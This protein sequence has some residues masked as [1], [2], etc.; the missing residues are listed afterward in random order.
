VSGVGS[1]GLRAETAAASRPDANTDRS[2]P[3]L[4]AVRVTLQA[5]DREVKL[6]LHASSD[7]EED[8][9]LAEIA[10]A[11]LRVS[12][13]WRPMRLRALL[14]LVCVLGGRADAICSLRRDRLVRDRL[15]VD[16]EI[17]PSIG[18]R[19]AKNFD[20]EETHWKPVPVEALFA[21]DAFCRLADRLLAD[22]PDYTEQGRC[23]RPAPPE[24]LA[25][26]PVSLRHP[27]RSITP[28]GFY[29]QLV[30]A[31]ARPVHGRARRLP[32]IE[33]PDGRGYS[34]H[35]LRGTV[36]QVIEGAA[37]RYCAEHG[38][39]DTPE[40]IYEALVD[41]TIPGD[42]HG[43][44]DRSSLRGRERLAK[45][46]AR[47]AWEMLA[48][49]KGARTV[50]DHD[51]FRTA[52]RQLQ[53]IEHELTLN[54]QQIRET[55][56]HAVG[57][58]ISSTRLLADLGVLDDAREELD[59]R[60]AGIERRIEDLRHDPATRVQVSDEIPGEDLIDRFDEIE[61]EINGHGSKATQP[62]LPQPVRD[63][64]TVPEVPTIFEI[65]YPQGA[66]W[67]NNKNLPHSPGDPRNPWRT[68][69]LPIDESLG[70]RRRRIPVSQISP[71]YLRTAAQRARLA[72][73]LAN[74]PQ[75]WSTEHCLAP[76][77][78]PDSNPRRPK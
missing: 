76:L 70:P 27:G 10:P 16:G 77:Q 56:E 18:L 63:W 30:G 64:F 32:L 38:L 29:Q 48:T 1:L 20:A 15:D 52:L 66:R 55:R 42:R 60:R 40:Q 61:E 75:G 24:D 12:G 28:Q 43:Y 54:R 31:P 21:V 6:R 35:T 11:R 5:V 34:P 36:M 68:H 7:E 25:M 62:E 74:W 78:R 22:T 65:S 50:R 8:E 26:F 51:G 46:G 17:G 69:P 59:E 53:A 2:S 4:R 13:L 39:N 3:S 37:K 19:P 72:Q 58:R 33:R 45:I 57:Q 44:L 41:H 73:I 67:V 49:E 71:A 47:I 9:R 14:T 23:E